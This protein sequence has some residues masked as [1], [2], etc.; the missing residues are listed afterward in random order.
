MS[1]SVIMAYDPTKV[2]DGAQVTV[3]TGTQFA[4]NAPAPRSDRHH[5]AHR[6]DGRAGHDDDRAG[7]RSDRHSFAVDLEPPAL[8]SPGPARRRRRR[9]RRS[10]NPT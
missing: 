7:L 10:P 1:G 6:L 9:P 3:I 2:V 4:V 5:R 8:G